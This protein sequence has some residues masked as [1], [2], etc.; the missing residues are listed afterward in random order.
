MRV[1]F[2]ELVHDFHVGIGG[3]KADAGLRISLIKEEAEELMDAVD[4]EDVIAAID[5]VCDLLYV[6]Y[7]TADV[8]GTKVRTPETMPHTLTTRFEN[9]SWSNIRN[10]ML[11]FKK[12]LDTA[13]K[14][15]EVFDEF[16]AL[17]KLH[18]TLTA[19]VYQTLEISDDLG[20]DVVP[21]FLEVHRT[22]MHKL[23]GPKRED[24]KQLKPEG[25]K[26][27]RIRAMYD[28][29]QQ[30]M[31]PHCDESCEARHLKYFRLSPHPEGGSVCM[32]CGG[33]VV[34]VVT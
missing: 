10:G 19:L 32:D 2:Q 8:Y 27:P 21:F 6:I 26:P 15:I 7:G 13:L 4:D 20:I 34:E 9:K 31:L 24:G 29:L 22:N 12:A 16:K 30:G 33:L 25:W 5:A 11:V 18:H 28:R 14:T 3:Q 1:D 17:G 23:T